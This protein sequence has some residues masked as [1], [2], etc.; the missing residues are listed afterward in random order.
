MQE[1]PEIRV[2]PKAPPPR[3]TKIELPDGV[4]ANPYPSA[5]SKTTAKQREIAPLD[6]ALRLVAFFAIGL[7][8]GS[9]FFSVSG[10]GLA[11]GVL[12]LTTWPKHR[13]EIIGCGVSIFIALLALAY[14]YLNEMQQRAHRERVS[15]LLKKGGIEKTLAEQEA[16]REARRADADRETQKLL[17]N[18]N[19]A[20]NN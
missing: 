8:L 12:T 13:L 20:W 3:L 9:A 10:I 17:D 2:P 15:E 19:R 5:T 11:V 16:E 1:T 6:F 4:D 7:M 18:A 14:P